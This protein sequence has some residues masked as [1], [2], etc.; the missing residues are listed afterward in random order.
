MI[1]YFTGTGNSRYLAQKIA[2]ATGDVL[3]SINDKIKQND[4]QTI[5]AEDRLVFVVPTYAWRIPRVVERWILNTR[6]TGA[7][8]AWFVMDCGGE[9]G[10]AETYNKR[11]C[12]QKQFEYMGTAQIVMPENYIAM[13]GTPEKEEAK[14]I[15]QKAEPVIEQAARRIAEGQI[16]SKPRSSLG[17][18]IMSGWIN[19]IFYPLFVK[20]DAFYAKDNCIGC[21]TCEKLCPLNNIRLEHERPVWGKNCTHCMA[22]ICHCPTGAIEYGRKSA[23]KPRYR[24]DE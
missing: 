24:C 7:N 9:I 18:R 6:F 5:D 15:I 8:K 21:G 4:P 22:C 23:G 12:E 11:L 17:D 1:L 16:F 20:A 10:N 2:N 19:P 3:V 13:F 14:Q